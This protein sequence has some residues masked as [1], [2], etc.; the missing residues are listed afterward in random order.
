MGS[1][2]GPQ[3]LRV[4]PGFPGLVTNLLEP[5]HNVAGA[6]LLSVLSAFFHEVGKAICLFLFGRVCMRRDF[7]CQLYRVLAERP[8][9]Q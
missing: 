6:S 3:P 9:A 2:Q 5:R 7:C 4:T 8:L 1:P